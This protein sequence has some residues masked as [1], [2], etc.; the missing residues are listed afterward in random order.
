MRRAH[1][2]CMD[3][4]TTVPRTTLPEHEALLDR[5]V[6]YLRTF[7]APPGLFHPDVVCTYYVP[8]GHYEQRGPDGM[9]AELAPYG[10]GADVVVK[11]KEVTIGGFVL[12][13]TQRARTGELYEELAWVRVEDGLVRELRVYCTGPVRSG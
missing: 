10:D 1:P 4:L 2:R 13:F 6:T 8:G 12:E 11:G 7:R 3:S 5:F 9:E